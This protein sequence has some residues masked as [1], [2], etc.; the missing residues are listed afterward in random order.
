MGRILFCS[1]DTKI[2][3]HLSKIPP[4]IWLMVCLVALCLYG[5]TYRKP[6]RKGSIYVSEPHNKS[7]CHECLYFLSDFLL[8][9]FFFSKVIVG[10]KVV[11]GSC[12]ENRPRGIFGCRLPFFLG[13]QHV[14]T[15]E[16]SE[17]EEFWGASCV[18]CTLTNWDYQEAQ[19]WLAD[20]YKHRAVLE[21]TMEQFRE[22]IEHRKFWN[23]SYF[24]IP[25]SACCCALDEKV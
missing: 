7:T 8:S 20:G 24:L 16:I 18:H 3:F 6:P 19:T 21:N 1:V 5:C 15:G 13:L 12:L 4:C 11:L 17:G 22:W 2:L 14:G 25:K 10:I 9:K 23:F